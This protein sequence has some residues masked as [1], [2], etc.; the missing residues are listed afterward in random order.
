[1]IDTNKLKLE[2]L[3]LAKKILLK[4]G[5]EDIKLIA[6]CDQAYF[7]NKIISAVAVLNY[8]D[9]SVAELKY[10]IQDVKFPYIS[11]YLSYRESPVILE[12]FNK[13]KK[14]PDLILVDGNGILHPRKIGLASH[15]GLILDKPT[16]GVAKNL[17]LGDEKDDKIFVENEP[18]AIIMKTRNFAKP[19]YV[20]P[21]HLVTLTNS[22]EI[23]KHC[24]RGSKLPEPLKVAHN[25]ANKIKRELK[26]GD[27]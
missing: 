15:L 5:F 10:T 3:K 24:L 6:G 19:I 8:K 13:L 16:V 12:T 9:L 20:S 26:E 18:R 2:Q 11:G 17:M 21:G 1:M 27:K 14:E 4:K 25:Y 23:V 22:L 7:Q